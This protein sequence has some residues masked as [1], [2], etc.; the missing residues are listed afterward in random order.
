MSGT[1]AADPAPAGR[2]GISGLTVC[3]GSRQVV[4]IDELRLDHG[5]ILGLAG[6]SGSGK[7]MTTL[8]ILG[9]AHTVGASVSGS[10]TLDG[11]ELIGLPEDKLRAIR[12]RR[13]AAIFQS[14][15]TAFNPVYRVGSIVTKALRLHGATKSEA[16]D[17]AAEAMRQVLLPPDL[18]RRYPSQLSGG[19]LQR[20][21]IALAIAL[22]AEILLAD[23]PTSALDVTVQAE[24]LD[25]LRDLRESIGM[26]ILFISHDL[27]VVAEL[28]DRVAVM[29]QGLIVEQGPARDVLSAPADPYT[30][31][32]LESVPKLASQP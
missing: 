19:Q 23:E 12:G 25:L 28:C 30:A 21:A 22:R 5:E 17:R 7:S 15:S 1:P 4:S 26:S 29:R 2:L 18:M 27:A 20:V 32:L 3:F 14:P 8:A 9:L 11:V 24:V 16:P 31:E 10:I 6:E 13:I